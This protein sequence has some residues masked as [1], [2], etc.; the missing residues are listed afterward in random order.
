[1][2]ARDCLQKPPLGGFFIA[3]ANQPS[4]RGG[5]RL[6]PALIPR[7]G[8]AASRTMRRRVNPINP[9]SRGAERAV[10][11]QRHTARLI[12]SWIAARA[13]HARNDGDHFATS[14]KTNHPL[15]SYA[16]ILMKIVST[17]FLPS[18]DCVW[19]HAI[20][21]RRRAYGHRFSFALHCAAFLSASSQLAEGF[22]SALALDFEPVHSTAGSTG[23]STQSIG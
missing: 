13:A 18:R 16:G 9:S 6:P 3:P 23:R 19:P 7:S 17:F 21:G 20:L 8:E 14:Q 4:C 1:M 5:R 12:Q 15:F 22:G 10:A 11:I 2:S